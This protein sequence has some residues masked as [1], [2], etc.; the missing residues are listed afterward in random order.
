MND[1]FLG[2]V[3]LVSCAVLII[4]YLLMVYAAYLILPEVEGRLSNCKLIRDTKAYVGNL[5]HFGRMYRYCMAG[6]V[7]T[8]TSL[9]LTKGMVDI[10]EVR[11]ISA[12]HRRWMCLPMRL[13]GVGFVFMMISAALR[14]DLW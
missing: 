5:G 6:M 11:G 2:V 10:D 13:G 8:S 9:L 14:G 7:F 1:F 3:L 12:R 4:G